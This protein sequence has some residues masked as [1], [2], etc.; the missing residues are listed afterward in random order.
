MIPQDYFDKVKKFYKGDE[1]KTWDWFT[2][3]H[4]R[5]G[6]LT[7]L[8]MIKLGKQQRVMNFINQEME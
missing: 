8:N 6:M 1:K 5:F 3:L 7:P 4:P 2:H